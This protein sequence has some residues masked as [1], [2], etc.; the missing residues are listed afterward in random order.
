MT[1]TKEDWKKAK[2]EVETIRDERYA[3]LK[4]TNARYD[5]ALA[6]LAAIE[7][8]IGCVICCCEGC[9]MPIV[10][11][12]PHL[13][14]DDGWL[15]KECAPTWQDLQD[16]PDLFE[17][18]DASDSDTGIVHH[19]PETAKQLIEDHLAA[20]GKMTDSLATP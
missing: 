14:I 4:P 11:G 7:E 16:S 13:V 5:D 20:G 9:L 12:E 2:A 18:V 19:T 1:Y 3:L 17:N 15:C 10:D 8:A 6:K